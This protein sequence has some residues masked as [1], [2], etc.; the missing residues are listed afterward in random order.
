[1]AIGCLRQG[2]AP[3][4]DKEPPCCHLSPPSPCQSRPNSAAVFL[5]P[6]SAT[7]GVTKPSSRTCLFSACCTGG[8]SDAGWPRSLRTEA[9]TMIESSFRRFGAPSKNESPNENRE[10]FFVFLLKIAKDCINTTGRFS[11]HQRVQGA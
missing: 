5:K 6:R 10:L 9:A 8:L 11:S 1:M 3:A 7:R 2:V 4:A